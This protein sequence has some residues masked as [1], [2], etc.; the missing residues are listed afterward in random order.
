MTLRPVALTLAVALTIFAA[1][2][3]AQDPVKP[4]GPGQGATN[5]VVLHEEKPT[6]TQDAMRAKIQG[7]VEVEAVVLA[8][9]LV[10]EVRI[11]KS[12]DRVFGLDQE[13][14]AAARKWRFRPATYNGQPVPFKVIIQLEFRLHSGPNPDAE[15]A[16]GA[17]RGSTP[18]LVLPKVKEEAKPGYTSQARD[19]K[20]EGVVELEAVVGPDGKVDRVRLTKSLDKEFGLDDEALRTARAWTFEP[21]TLNGKPVPVLVVIQLEF[22]VR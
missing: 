18:G 12:L 17:Y 13:A 3:S 15:F 14:L 22:R 2:V 5:P 9:G 1:P 4:M 10:G 20:I 21:G 16:R 19:R 7:V 8:S 11:H 6:Y